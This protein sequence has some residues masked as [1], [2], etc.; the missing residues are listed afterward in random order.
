MLKKDNIIAVSQIVLICILKS[1]CKD[2]DT[3]S[4]KQLFSKISFDFNF[5]KADLEL[6]LV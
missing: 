3:N 6:Q 1:L 2:R 5:F 4:H